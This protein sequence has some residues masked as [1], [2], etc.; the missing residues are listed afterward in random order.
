M[1]SC[2]QKQ[3]RHLDLHFVSRFPEFQLGLL[4]ARLD[5]EHNDVRCHQVSFGHFNARWTA[6][7]S[8]EHQ[9]HLPSGHTQLSSS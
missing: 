8:P 3:H 4:M 7:Q 2:S 6:G 9:Q 5:R 1:L